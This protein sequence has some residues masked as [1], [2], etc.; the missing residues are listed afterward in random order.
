MNS[1][2]FITL[3]ELNVTMLTGISVEPVTDSIPVL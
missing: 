3:A 1:E 2:D